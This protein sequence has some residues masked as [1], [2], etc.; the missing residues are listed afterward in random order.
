MSDNFI[1]SAP[2]LDQM[3]TNCV[4]VTYHE[5]GYSQTFDCRHWIYVIFDLKER[6]SRL[7]L[8]GLLSRVDEDTHTPLL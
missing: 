7:G 5:N 6:K 8:R 4:P 3:S 1:K 2:Y